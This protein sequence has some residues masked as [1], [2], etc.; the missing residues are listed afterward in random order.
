MLNGGSG[1]HPSPTASCEDGYR[2]FTYL[3]MLA[4]RDH[5]ESGVMVRKRC[6]WVSPVLPP[7]GPKLVTI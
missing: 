7:V 3:G 1:Q 2:R 5:Y 6:L 4:E